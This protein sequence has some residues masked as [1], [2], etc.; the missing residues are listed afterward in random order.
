[1]ETFFV[2]SDFK[3][4]ESGTWNLEMMSDRNCRW[5][6]GGCW[7][8]LGGGAR[9]SAPWARRAPEASLR[10][11]GAPAQSMGARHR[12]RQPSLS[13]IRE[14]ATPLPSLA[15]V[16]GGGAPGGR[17]QPRRQA[18]LRRPPLQLQQTGQACRQHLRRAACVHQAQTIPAHRCRKSTLLLQLLRIRIILLHA[19]HTPSLHRHLNICNDRNL[20]LKRSAPMNPLLA[21]L[22]ISHHPFHTRTTWN[23]IF[24]TDITLSHK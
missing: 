23:S 4:L 9:A 17:R 19:P 2:E 22:I 24:H 5:S 13:S 20:P 10:L 3:I 11:P 1:M 12:R 14:H 16:F 15:A 18:T 6:N 8:R 21:G 7:G